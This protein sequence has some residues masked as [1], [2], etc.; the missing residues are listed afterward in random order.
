MSRH[1]QLQCYRNARILPPKQDA[2]EEGNDDLSE[3]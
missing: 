1:P 2:D 3:Q